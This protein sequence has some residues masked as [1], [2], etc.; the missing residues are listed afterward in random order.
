MM[1]KL[2][3]WFYFV[4]L[5]TLF[6]GCDIPNNMADSSTLS[7]ADT[8]DNSNGKNSLS[9]KRSAVSEEKAVNW[10]IRLQAED[11]AKHTLS[12]SAQLGVLDE[13]D[14]TVKHTL[15]AFPPMGSGYIDIVFRNPTGVDA[16]D[17]KTYFQQFAENS[18]YRWRFTVRTD[19]SNAQIALTWR[20]VYV[21][22]PYIDT[23][24]RQRYKETK[25]MSNPI[26]KNMQLIDVDT[27]NAI[28]VLSGNQ[29]KIY[30]FNM[31]GKTEKTFEWV[32]LPDSMLTSSG[33]K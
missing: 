31:N 22:T 18:E 11:T 19:D 2:K 14:A 9:L 1:L 6:V 32:V 13:E 16:G 8:T 17:Y 25:S 21:L 30:Y 3:K 24:G 23:E 33:S 20:G 10:Y 15:S 12:S 29:A 4:M 27:G 5:S 26:I 28:N 7:N